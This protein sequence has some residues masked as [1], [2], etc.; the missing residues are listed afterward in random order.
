[1]PLRCKAMVRINSCADL[2]FSGNNVYDALGGDNGKAPSANFSSRKSLPRNDSNPISQES[3]IVN[4]AH[5]DGRSC[6]K[7]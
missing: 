5:F 6:S 3:R 7:E 4:I 1:M 2:R